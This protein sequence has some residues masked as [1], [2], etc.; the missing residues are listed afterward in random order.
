MSSRII[1]TPMKN[2]TLAFIA[3][4]L[5]FAAYAD[6]TSPYQGQESRKIKALSQEEVEGYLNGKGLGY[7]KAAELNQYPGPRHVLDAAKELA[8]SDEQ[9]KRTQAIFDDMQQRAI[10]LGKQ[11]VAKE[12]EL[13]R[14]FASGT[15]DASSL[16]ALLAEIGKIQTDI[17]YVHLNAH[18]QQ[19]TVL[20]KHQIHL[21]NQLRGYNAA[22][23]GEHHHAH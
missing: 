10:K 20:S 7:A 1:K 11:L 21:Y 17:R 13:D 2:L 6:T 16:K 22:N 18:L 19:V 15:A 14:Q 9:T 23:D 5:T 4:A 8:L 12:Q 3:C